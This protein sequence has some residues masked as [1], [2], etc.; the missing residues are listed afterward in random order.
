MTDSL[1]SSDHKSDADRRDVNMSGREDSFR[2]FWLNFDRDFPS[3]GDDDD[4]GMFQPD[5]PSDDEDDAMIDEDQE[6]GV[7]QCAIDLTRNFKRFED[8]T[9]LPVH[10]IFLTPCPSREELPGSLFSVAQFD[11]L[12][13]QSRLHF[14][15][16]L[17]SIRF[18]SF[19]AS[20]DSILTTFLTMLHS[21]NQ[22]FL[23]SVEM[24]KNMNDLFGGPPIFKPSL[25]DP[26]R[27]LI[28]RSKEIIDKVLSGA[29]L[30]EVLE[31]PIF[32]EIQEVFA[33]N[34]EHRPQNFRTHSPWSQ[35]ESAL[36]ET[37]ARRFDSLSDIQRFSM[38]ARSV[39]MLETYCREEWC[40]PRRDQRPLDV[41]EVERQ[42]ALINRE[43][44]GQRFQLKDH[45]RFSDIQEL[46]R[47][48]GRK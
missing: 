9:R 33:F 15:L 44:D 24:A 14:A 30:D 36:L 10:Q 41:E 34:G 43:A 37:A 28:P 21:F 32:S 18:V 42:T 5:E 35:E 23:S 22:I 17:R 45:M 19:C 38:P 48:L 13:H 27:S 4:D 25:G 2:N 12:R 47:D 26:E 46:P 29:T 8:K 40:G 6:A 39:R 7:S 11:L 16:L 3:D 31:L 1:E 20:S